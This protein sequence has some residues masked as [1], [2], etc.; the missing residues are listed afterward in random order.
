M[1]YRTLEDVEAKISKAIAEKSD[2]L[3]LDFIQSDVVL[4]VTIN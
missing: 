4:P 2:T 3:K 1:Y